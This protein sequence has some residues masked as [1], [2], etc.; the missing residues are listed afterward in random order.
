VASG[1]G[2]EGGLAPQGGS[3]PDGGSLASGAGGEGGSTSEGGTTASGGS[4]D[5][6]GSTA[7]AGSTASGG[8]TA[9]PDLVLW[10]K[11]DETSGTSASDSSGND[12][13][14]SLVVLGT[15]SAAFSTTHQVGTGSV[16]LTSTSATNGAYITVPSSLSDMGATT[17]ITL[18]CWVNVPSVASWSRVFDFGNT[19]TTGYLFLTVQEGVTTPYAPRFA[20]TQTDRLAEQIINMTTPTGLSAGVWHHFAVVLAAGATYTGTL[21]LDG[22]AAGSNAAMTL[23]PSDL[24]ATAQNW[25]GRSQFTTADPL[26]SGMLDD[27]RIYKRALTASEIGALYAGR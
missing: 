11:F 14:G 18:A 10:Y 19:S 3:A 27:F 17:E 23:R 25:L 15:G 20:I 22:A 7:A 1:A 4:T 13:T 24:G 8:T 16:N 26:F 9:D 5:A 21:Y 12:R 6:G 2:G